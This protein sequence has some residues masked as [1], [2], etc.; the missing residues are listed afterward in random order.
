MVFLGIVVEDKTIKYSTYLAPFWAIMV[1]QSA[2]TLKREN[3]LVVST[4]VV[5][6]T[7]FFATGLYWQTASIFNKANYP[8]LNRAIAGEIPY[9]ATC[10]APMNFI[11]NEIADYKIFSDDLVAYENFGNTIDIQSMSGFCRKNRCEYVVFNKYG[12]RWDY[13]HDYNDTSKLFK[14]FGIVGANDEYVVLK[15]EDELGKDISTSSVQRD[16]LLTPYLSYMKQRSMD[17][18]KS[19]SEK[20]LNSFAP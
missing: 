19:K 12:D 9:H 14:N 5:L 2:A 20:W 16:S 13:I 4:N 15:Y 1:A 3:R 18:L 17:Y 6:F 10:V 8:P 11:F 7:L